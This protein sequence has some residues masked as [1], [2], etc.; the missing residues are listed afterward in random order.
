MP[1]TNRNNDYSKEH[2][3]QR[4]LERYGKTINDKQYDQIVNTVRKMISENNNI[5][6][7]NK[8]SKTNMQYVVSLIFEDQDILAVFETERNTVTTFLPKN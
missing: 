6:G 8:M 5:K 1:K 4:F 7:K 2:S 3:R